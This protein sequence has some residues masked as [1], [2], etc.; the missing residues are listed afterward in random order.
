M[1]VRWPVIVVYTLCVAWAGVSRDNLQEI[2]ARMDQAAA[3]F[4]C[5]TAKSTV[6]QHTDVINENDTES[7]S[8]IMKKVGPNQ[9]EGLLDFTEPANARRTVSFSSRQAKI[10]YPKLKTIDVYDLGTFGEQIDQFIMIGFG[11][12]GAELAR[13]YVV[14]LAG[15][16][17]VDGQ[18]AIRL[19]LLP[20]SEDAKKYVTKLELWIPDRGAPYPL[21]EKIYEPS[22][23]YRLITYS[24]V[25]IN[26]PLKGDAVKLKV[27]AG[28]K[29]QQK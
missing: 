9:V 2:L 15:E 20:K 14:K 17:L 13:S 28:V 27:P 8:V 4:Q 11:T 18:P 6:V 22:G 29:I 5:M 21:R 19:E 26:P 10:Y 3:S 24:D 16:E 1:Q 25:K 23:D 7:T 12:S